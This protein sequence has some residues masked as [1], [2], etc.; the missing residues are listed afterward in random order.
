[1]INTSIPLPTEKL[2]EDITFELI[3]SKSEETRGLY[4]GHN[5]AHNLVVHRQVN[6]SGYSIADLIVLHK[7]SDKLAATILELKNVPLS[8]KDINQV[9]RYRRAL[10]LMEIFEEINCILI[11]TDISDGH[12]ILNETTEKLNAYAF[13]VDAMDG[14]KFELLDGSFYIDVDTSAAM[15]Q[16]T[17]F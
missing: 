17:N 6:L 10:E 2:L 8:S 9:F 4:L 16:L 1:M 15:Q 7:Y 3:A 14:L 11:G 5:E 13:R 12:Y